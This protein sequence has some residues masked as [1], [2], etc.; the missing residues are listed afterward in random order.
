MRRAKVALD[1]RCLQDR[2]P[3]GIARALANVVPLLA[4]E[5]D[6]TLLYAGTAAEPEDGIVLSCALPTRTAWLQLAVPRWVRG[7]E[8]LFHCPFYGLPYVQPVPMVV[9]LWD[10]TFEFRPDWFPRHKRLA[11]R[12]QARHA[13]RTARRIIVASE[14]VK[15]DVSDRYQVAPDRI[16]VS[17]L[18]ADSRFVPR[19]AQQLAPVL[20]RFG[21]RRRYVVA[22]G[23]AARRRLD[24]AVASWRHAGGEEL[25]DLVIVGSEES[26]GPAATPGVVRIGAV[27][28][29]T[30]AVVLAG[31]EAFLYPT[32]YEGFGMP[33]V[34]AQAA[35][36]PVVCG[37]VGSLPEVLGGVAAWADELT[38]EG[39]A[40]PLGKVVSDAAARESMVA[41]GLASI[42][43]RP[44]WAEGAAAFAD[45]YRGALSG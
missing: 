31:A 14:T 32:E 12:S 35:G 28:D 10:L 43:G 23:G 25:C 11:F 39:L 3:G 21:I 1:A 30:L 20:E 8:G 17:P 26:H 18:S 29:E 4:D 6:I 34:E 15:S 13:A 16:V 40:L 2:P 5:F 22:L 27:D 45:A 41:A 36:V 44:G 42:R 9:S 7:F 19:T 37:R 38:V 24:L 33:A